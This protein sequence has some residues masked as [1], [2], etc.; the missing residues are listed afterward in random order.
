MCTPET[1]TVLSTI[2]HLNNKTPWDSII[3]IPKA[4]FDDPESPP[5]SSVIHHS[6][7]EKG[8]FFEAQSFFQ[9][10]KKKLRQR[11]YYKICSWLQS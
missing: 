10:G 3:T 6:L 5:V 1:N 2:F 9:Y 7:L 4:R 11:G 8:I